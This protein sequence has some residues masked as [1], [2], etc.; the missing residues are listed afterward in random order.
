MKTKDFLRL[1]IKLFGLY[2]LVLSLFTF[3][4]QTAGQ[5]ISD[6]V[7]WIDIVGYIFIGITMICLF[8]WLTFK[9]DFLINSLK[10]DKGFDQD[11]IPLDKLDSAAILKIGCVAIGGIFFLDNLAEFIS[12]CFYMFKESIQTSI[13]EL[14]DTNIG[15]SSRVNLIINV[16]NLIIGYL[17]VTSHA[18]IIRFLLKEG[19]PDQGHSSE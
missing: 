15:R 1:I 12:G 13:Q 4:P 7:N 6:Y 14:L 18:S 19:N 11:K 9:P 16:I 5:L 8:L 17:L 10:L 2:S 3:I